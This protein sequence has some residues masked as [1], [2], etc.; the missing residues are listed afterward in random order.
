MG[1]LSFTRQRPGYSQPIAN[2]IPLKLHMN[3]NVAVDPN[4]APAA[5]RT[6]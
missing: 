2:G 4:Q 3:L 5:I 1:A 6:C